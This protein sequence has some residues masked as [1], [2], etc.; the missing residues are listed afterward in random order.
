MIFYESRYA[1]SFIYKAYD[2]RRNS[3]QINVVRNFP[4]EDA[5]F[6]YYTWVEGDRIDLL[7]NTYLGN[8]SFWWKLLDYNPEIID[9]FD[10]P[11]GTLV[12][13]PSV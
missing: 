1:D 2:A 11:V 9:V 13:I 7:A 3:Y 5:G 4:T 8:P 12:R 6:F 10:I